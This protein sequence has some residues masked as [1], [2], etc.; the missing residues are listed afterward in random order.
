MGT[1]LYIRRRAENSFVKEYPSPVSFAA[2]EWLANTENDG[3]IS[4]EHARNKGEHKVGVRRIP[5][6]GY[7]RCAFSLACCVTTIEMKS[8]STIFI[9]YI[10]TVATMKIKFQRE[11]HCVPV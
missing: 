3:N 4:I 10:S 11:K 8:F 2:T 5:V 7:C 9:K 1:G 6:D